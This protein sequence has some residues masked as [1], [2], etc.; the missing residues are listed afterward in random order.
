MHSQYQ[1]NN[2][3]TI[4]FNMTTHT[5]NT[6]PAYFQSRFGYTFGNTKKGFSVQPYAGYSYWIQNM[7]KS[8]YGGHLTTGVQFRYQ[9]TRIALLYADFNA[10]AAKTFLFSVGIA[11]KLPT[12]K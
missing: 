3:F 11:G 2:R 4:G 5:D 12:K 7:E 1:F 9:I 8:S 10:P 6:N